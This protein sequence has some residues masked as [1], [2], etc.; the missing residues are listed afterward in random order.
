MEDEVARKQVRRG[1]GTK[2]ATRK[3]LPQ[4]PQTP[5]KVVP[6]NVSG[7]SLR[8]DQVEQDLLTGQHAGLLEDYFGE[9][10]YRE[11]RELSREAAATSRRGGPRV[12]ILPGIMGSKLGK[13]RF[14]IFDDVLWID[15]IDIARGQLIEL[16]LNGA[17]TKYKAVGVV[18]L[19]YLKLKLR[20]KIGGYDVDFYPFDW[21]LGLNVLG[22]QL[23]QRLAQEHAQDI[24]LVA[25]S[26]GGLVARAAIAQNAKKVKRLIMLGTP[27]YGSFAIPQA[28]RGTYPMVQKIDK[29]DLRHNAEELVEQVF[30]T[31]P[32]LYHMMPAQEKFNQVNLYTLD[33]WPQNGP[34]PR[35]ALL[36]TI[37]EARKGLADADERFFLIAGVNQETATSLRR[38]GDEFVYDLSLDGDGTVPLDF[39]ELPGAKTYYVEESHGS[40]PNNGT[41]ERAVMDLLETGSTTVLP[42]HWT[43]STRGPV[44]SVRDHELRVP[45]FEGRRG[46]E[47]SQREVRHLIEEVA[48][49]VAHETGRTFVT[50][51]PGIATREVAQAYSLDRVVVGR[52]RQHRIDLRLA[53]GSITEAD[54]HAYVLGVFRDVA[55]SGAARALDTRLEGAITEFTARR[56]FSGNVGEVFIMPSG[57]HA[58][59]ADVTLFVGLGPFDRFGEEVQQLVAANVM[60]TL[61][62][63]RIEDFATV[64]VG[65]GSGRGVAS[66]LRNL[67]AGFIRG[68]RDTDEEYRFRSI[69]LCEL[70]RDRFETMKQELYRLSGTPLFDEVE[71]TFHETTLRPPLIAEP[72][73]QVARGPEPAYLIVAQ[74]ASSKDMM[75]FRSSVLTAGAKATVITS[76]K[77]VKRR[78]LDGHLGRIQQQGAFTYNTLGNFGIRLAELVLG[79]EV[80]AVLPTIKDHH[81][82]VAHD[83]PASRIPWETLYI[84]D[85]SPA[86]EAGLS[87]KYIADNLSIAKWLEQRR[88][89]AILD[90]LLVVNPTEDL[91]GAE[92]EGERIRELFGSH[93]AVSIKQL[94]QREATKGAVLDALRSGQ[95]DVVHYAGHAFFDE[96]DPARSGIRCSGDEVLSGAEL[97]GVGNLPALMFFNA[98]EAARVRARGAVRSK[99]K[100]DPVESIQHTIGLAEAFLRGGVANYI[101]TYWPVGDAAA[102][103]FAETFY[104]KL[105]NG[106]S[107]GKALQEGRAELQKMKSIDWAD[108]VH[109]GSFGFVL[110]KA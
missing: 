37:K 18:L 62:R 107:I 47:L 86:A 51:V 26:M 15:P 6:T 52:R 72:T 88:F 108:Y 105:L 4:P 78:D 67:L 20:L 28:L 94:H 87:R 44:R 36:D 53:L 95:Y 77:E 93:P 40:L 41:V 32:G 59:P 8:D 96:R 27:N 50:E 66:S 64:L 33:A 110:K 24:Y 22:T 16:A 58:L 60:R 3:K 7:Y 83:A 45:A 54:A 19:A 79:A 75:E 21:R 69:T 31:F 85:W 25:H 91:D 56:M 34:R 74:Q 65:A 39:A 1:R 10:N 46:P 97:A 98:C 61:I 48:S 42:D 68:L 109:Y 101:G 23:V 49:P 55:P 106:E 70:D 35:P 92:E 9:Q 100:F 29:L 71:V 63:T 11:L 17:V 81:L 103:A 73:R 43:R 12:L 104:T 30:S 80:A 57:R 84:G 99:S 102:K 13:P 14:K 89:G 76:V 5:E 82:I 2:A 38:E 90:L